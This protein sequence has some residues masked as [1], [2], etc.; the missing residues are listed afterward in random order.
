MNAEGTNEV[1]TISPIDQLAQRATT[2]VLRLPPDKAGITDISKIN[3]Q[4]MQKYISEVLRGYGS[5]VSRYVH[6]FSPEIHPSLRGAQDLFFIGLVSLR[7][8]IPAQYY[9]K[10]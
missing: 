1:S 4:E 10:Y 5:L 8:G 7:K 6:N 3:P 9:E 2:A